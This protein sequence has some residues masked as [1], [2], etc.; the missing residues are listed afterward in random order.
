MRS[1]QIRPPRVFV[2]P[3]FLE[4]NRASDATGQAA[5]LGLAPASSAADAQCREAHR[6]QASSTTAV[7]VLLWSSATRDLLKSFG[8]G[9]AVLHRLDVA[10]KLPFPGRPPIASFDPAKDGL[11]FLTAAFGRSPE[12]LRG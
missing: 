5:V 11:E 3:S 6:Q 1:P 7:I 4:R 12:N 10:T 8:W 2:T 9:I